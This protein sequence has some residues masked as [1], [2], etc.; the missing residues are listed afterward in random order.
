LIKRLGVP[1]GSPYPYPQTTALSAT[2]LAL[3]ACPAQPHQVD[4]R[5]QAKRYVEALDLDKLLEMMIPVR[6]ISLL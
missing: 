2:N 3:A 6:A 4:I 1:N 5:E